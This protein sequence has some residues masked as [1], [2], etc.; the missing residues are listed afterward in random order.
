MEHSGASEQHGRQHRAEQAYRAVE[1]LPKNPSVL[2]AEQM[3]TSPVVSLTPEARITGALHQCQTNTFRHV[4]V[5]TSA[6]RLAV[7]IVSE[8]DILRYLAGVSKSYQQQIPHTSD[9][10]V[11]Q[12]MTPRV[13]TASV[14]PM[15]LTLPVCSSNSISGQCRLPKTVS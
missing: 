6:G 8:R 10:Q 5:V 9:A 7:G 1:Q 2:L 4:P 13:L 14:A 12:L 11:G 15:C 3:M